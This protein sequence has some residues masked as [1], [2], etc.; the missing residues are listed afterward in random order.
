VVFLLEILLDVLEN[1]DEYA[2]SSPF[3]VISIFPEL[4]P[5]AVN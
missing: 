3:I 2:I 4:L 1:V 5:S